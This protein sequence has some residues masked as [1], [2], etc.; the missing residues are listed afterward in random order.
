[1]LKREELEMRGGRIAVILAAAALILAGWG[2]GPLVAAQQASGQS[3]RNAPAAAA[4]N[5]QRSGE[6]TESYQGPL[7]TELL[8]MDQELALSPEQ[9][10]HLQAL[11]NGFEKEAIRVQGEIQT[12]QVD[13]GDLLRISPPDM[14]KVE[15]QEQR[16][17]SLQAQLRTARIKAVTEARAVLTQE[18]WQKFQSTRFAGLDQRR[19]QGTPGYGAYGG[20]G[21]GPGMMG[22]YGPGG[23]SPDMMHG[24]GPW[25]YGG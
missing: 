15:A 24:Y 2:W 18:Q 13:L 6:S 10:Q 8:S 21:M 12:A 4:R 23:Y 20:Y 22:G 19:D 11:R 7:I 9:V 3:N 14:Q 16:I 25:G 1:M 17:A 5:A